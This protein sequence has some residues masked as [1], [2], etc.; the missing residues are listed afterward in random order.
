[1]T[2]HDTFAQFRSPLRLKFLSVPCAALCIL[3]LVL[4]GDLAA[5]EQ[6]VSSATRAA[7]IPL[8]T[9][10]EV[11]PAPSATG[12]TLWKPI[13][14]DGPLTTPVRVSNVH[15][16]TDERTI[17]Q[18]NA[19]SPVTPIP[20]QEAVSNPTEAA[21]SEK[22]AKAADPPAQE[23]VA[24]TTPKTITLEE[25][26]RRQTLVEQQTDLPEETKTQLL[27]SYHRATESLRLLAESVKKT[28]SLKAERDQAPELIKTVRTELNTP[29]AK[30]DL[31]IEPQS[32]VSDLE[33]RKLVDDEQANEAIRA[34]EA[35]EA[36]A[37]VR[38]E[39]KPQM[40]ALIEKTKQQITEAKNAL[41]AP[42]V[43]GESANA[44]LA[45]KTEQEAFLMLLQQQLEQYRVEQ[46]R[47][48]ALSEYFPLERDKLIRKKNVFEKRLE[49]WKVAITEARR[50]ESER[51]A[52]E[53]KQKLR[54]THPALREIAE[55]NTVLTEQRKLAHSN[56]E[57]AT[58]TL[59]EIEEQY[60]TISKS[61][62][63]M[64]D[65]ESLGALS[66]GVGMLLRNQ[67]NRLPSI[68]RY[69]QKRR[70]AEQEISRLQLEL[71]PLQDERDELSDLETHVESVLSKLGQISTMSEEEVHSMTL[72]LLDDR[73]KYLDDLIS[74]YNVAMQ[75]NGDID[76]KGRLLV[77]QIAEY[78]NFIDE[79]ILWIRSASVVGPTTIPRA[80]V[81]ARKVFSAENIDR[82][83]ERLSTDLQEYRWAYLI[84]LVTSLA[85]LGLT[86]RI[87][88]LITRL[89][90]KS[91]HHV[92]SNVV[93][94]LIAI[95]LTV[96]SASV[97]PVG[98][99]AL[100]WRL[101]S[102]ATADFCLACGDALKTT[103][104]AF[105]SMEVFRQLCR[106]HGIAEKF[107]E[108]SSKSMR[109]IHWQLLVLLTTGLPLMFL[110]AL[111]DSYQEGYWAD[112]VG[113]VAFVL[114]CTILTV[115]A[116]RMLK[117]SGKILRNL[118]KEN[119]DGLMYQTRKFWYPAAILAP[120]AL[121]A[122]SL[123]GYQYTAEQ[124][125]IRLQFT[126]WLS[127]SIVIAYTI[128]TQWM[129]VARKK[130]AMDQARARRAATLAANQQATSESAT[131]PV[132]VVEI[133][134][135]D[136]SA[137]NQQMIKLLRVVACVVF[138][139]GS[140]MIWSQV[141]PALQVF[142]R[143][144]LWP[145]IV[146]LSEAVDIGEGQTTIQTVT[147]QEW[148]TLGDLFVAIGVMVVAVLASKNLPGLLELSILQRLPLD[149]GERNAVTTMCR[150]A[151]TLIG[152]IFA[153]R[154]IGIGWSSVQWLVAAL[155]V[156]LGF[157]L[158]EIFANF[159]SGL[160]I[161]FE[162]PIRIGDVVT[163]DN[164][165]GSVNRI[166]IRATT[167]VDWDRKEYIVPNK[168]FVTGRLLNW[169]LSD[170]TNR[171]VI[172]VGVAYGS[173]VDLALQLLMKVA[174]DHPALLSD[175][176]PVSTFEGFGDS[177][178]SLVLRAY[179]PNLDNRL[180][181]ITELH[182]EID[183]EFRKAKIEIAFPQMDLHVRD[184]NA[185]GLQL[186]TTE[187]SG[188]SKAA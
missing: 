177:N 87:R 74:D 33:R 68:T 28:T 39:R 153:C 55:R 139:S 151:C 37:K 152:V 134:Q 178:L 88:V 140:W 150:Y 137:L 141:M 86:N 45:R 50:L 48:E 62:Q 16:L 161:L 32:S 112:S 5:Q 105:W 13:N 9:P 111:A 36:R 154:T 30:T 53:A 89:V 102:V 114:F 8:P 81:G 132:P 46:S 40:A 15:R 118:L 91:N 95:G 58:E 130:L 63:D 109:A 167:I 20:G 61:Y 41:E 14:L 18:L 67:R 128:V 99:W 127:M 51:Q 1:M 107:L 26:Q 83:V 90:D 25:I 35:W 116:A 133:P 149:H 168:E 57:S 7:E 164:V 54:E 94:T 181:V 75:T 179:L 143:V 174:T 126:F 84:A 44:T 171:I 82:S 6:L 182:R 24:E 85:V 29:A 17:A 34:L 159:V 148:V 27:Q 73:R 166:K 92:S 64:L 158:Q 175:P 79:R 96:I 77:E 185:A 56:L 183:L 69:R 93:S 60:E 98:L 3:S 71:L 186:P 113:R 162:R 187:Q 173:D 131:S 124:L 52:R 23:T 123:Y 170:K 21:A 100:G 70:F 188:Q 47:Y 4:S 172:N 121:G 59:A 106:K 19:S 2:I 108:W 129:L 136:L 157:G 155:T 11:F 42:A 104:L 78:E 38:S 138:L 145:T 22:A 76:A 117:P 49:N 142:N 160:I 165:T 110:T 103:A 31:Q 156:G 10:E 125:L 144:E 101:S 97:L 72:G 119:Q 66:T 146:N 135:V 122:L 147:R 163:I 184:I 120:A 80:I 115:M 12:R 180:K 176:G 43:E 65:K 169:T